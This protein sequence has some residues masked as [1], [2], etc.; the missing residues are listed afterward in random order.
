MS[1][2]EEIKIVIVGDQGVGKSSI[3]DRFV[4]GQ[5]FPNRK[6]TVG[7]DCH[8]KLEVIDERQYKVILWDTAGQERFNALKGLY[9][10]AALGAVIVFDITK[11]STFES[12]ASR[13]V[14]DVKQK[15]DTDVKILL[16][17]NKR[18]NSHNAEVD[19]SLAKQFAID[20]KFCKYFTTS[21]LNNENIRESFTYLLKE[22]I[23]SK[24]EDDKRKSTIKLENTQQTPSSSSTICNCVK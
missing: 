4:N 5:F 8:P 21:A 12:V 13:W 14:T 3:L 1:Q 16:V 15:T 6:T 9:Y 20:N 7:F 18:D 2:I 11:S 10:K 23:K 17:G 19:E 22:I 24:K